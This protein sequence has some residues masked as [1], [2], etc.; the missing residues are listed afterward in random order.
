VQVNMSSSFFLAAQLQALFYNVLA[1]FED[2]LNQ[3]LLSW[4]WI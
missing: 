3:R 1:Q 4:S 2:A